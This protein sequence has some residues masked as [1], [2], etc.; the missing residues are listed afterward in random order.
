M[1]PTRSSCMIDLVHN[2]NPLPFFLYL[3]YRFTPSRRFFPSA[4]QIGASKKYLMVSHEQSPSPS[5]RA[6]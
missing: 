2:S 5:T 6:H 1:R 3:L 4:H